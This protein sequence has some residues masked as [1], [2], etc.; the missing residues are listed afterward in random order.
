MRVLAMPLMQLVY[1]HYY[2]PSLNAWGVITCVIGA[3]LATAAAV[4]VRLE[5]G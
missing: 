1:L 2:G 3:V 4:I 5:Q